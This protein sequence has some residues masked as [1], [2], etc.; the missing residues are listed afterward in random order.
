MYFL[1]C[2]TFCISSILTVTFAVVDPGEGPEPPNPP[3]LQLLDQTEAQRAETFF[4]RPPPP[5]P[6]ISGSGRLGSP[7]I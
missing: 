5:P 6:F 2:F 4:F 3:P 7:L 1:E